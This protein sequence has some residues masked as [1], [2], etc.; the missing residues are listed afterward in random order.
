MRNLIPAEW[1]SAVVSAII[2]CDAVIPVFF[3]GSAEDVHARPS[4]AYAGEV[5]V[6]LLSCKR[7][8]VGALIH[9]GITLMGA[10]LDLV[11]G[12]IVLHIAMVDALTN[13]A[14]DCFV[15]LHIHAF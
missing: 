5:F 6:I 9:G 2:S 1:R 14:F 7:H 8:A 3:V 13:G 4:P 10:D 12:T 15:S 11:Q